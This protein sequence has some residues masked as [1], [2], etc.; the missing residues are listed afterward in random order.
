MEKLQTSINPIRFKVLIFALQAVIVSAPAL[1]P[2]AESQAQ[3]ERRQ[4]QSAPQPSQTARPTTATG[5]NGETIDVNQIIRAVAAKETEFRQAL[6]QYG[7]KRDI[8][9]QTIG[10]GGQVSGE[11]RRVSTFAF[12]DQGTRFER[13][14]FAPI[15]TIEALRMT[16]EDFEDFGGVNAFA[17]ESSKIDQYNF[18]YAGRERIDEI[19]TYVFD[20]AP[21]VIPRRVSER[22]FQ[23]RIWV[24]DRDL[25]IVKARGRGV[26]EE[27]QR[28]PLFESYREQVDGRYWFPTYTYADDVLEFSNGNRVHVRLIIRFSEFQRFRGRLTIIEDDEGTIP[29]EPTP[30]PSPSPSPTPR[31]P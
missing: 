7:F 8:T 29:T 30:A 27:D 28:F 19:G 5:P 18:T 14:T 20:V 13:I 25:Q 24:D 12:G 16:P 3:Q 21:R 9:F 17:L 23:G 6:N 11:F 1:F 4:Q 15:S 26:P 10:L 31:R 2:S 22:F